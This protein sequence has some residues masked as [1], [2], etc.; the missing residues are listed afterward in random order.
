[1]PIKLLLLAAIALF[2]VL[3]MRGT[4][5]AGHRALWRLM[6]LLVLVLGAVSVV[7]P[8]LVTWVANGLGIGRGADLLLYALAVTSLLV[9]TVIF[10]R[11]GELEAR[12]VE[13]TRQIAISDAERAA[14]VD[15]RTPNDELTR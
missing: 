1:M 10:R 14:A 3:A 9:V 13:L 6:G 8:A 4:H 5:S 11:M 7:F 15:R 2:G 12:I